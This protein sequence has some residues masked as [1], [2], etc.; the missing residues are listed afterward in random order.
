MA[1]L[2]LHDVVKD[3]ASEAGSFRALHGVSFDVAEGELMSIMGPSGS[4]KSTLMN[5][6][7]CLDVPSEGVFRFDGQ[8]VSGLDERAQASLRNRDI[9]FVFQQ[10]NL[11]P[12]LSALGNVALPLVYAG[13]ARAEREARAAELLGLVGLADKPASRPSQLSGGQQQRVAVARALATQPRLLLADEPTGALD[14]RT[15]AEVL[16]MFKALNADRGVTVV[17]VT[18]DPGVAAATNRVVRI[19]DGLILYDGP[20]TAEALAG[21]GHDFGSVAAC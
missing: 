3:Y 15:G 11:L 1:L 5:I 4:G 13:V 18:H 12:R 7:G 14:T 6:I 17:I 19:Q 20:P 9:G 10:F 2:S 8:D 21:A 16:A